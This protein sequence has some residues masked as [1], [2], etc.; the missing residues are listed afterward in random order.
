M[1]RTSYGS[2][3]DFCLD[4]QRLQFTVGLRDAPEIIAGILSKRTG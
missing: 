4:L 2:S 1:A 3:F